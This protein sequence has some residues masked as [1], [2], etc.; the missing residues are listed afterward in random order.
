MHDFIFKAA[1]DKC[2]REIIIETD[3][4]SSLGEEL[5]QLFPKCIYQNEFL[6]ALSCDVL[7]MGNY[8]IWSI[9]DMD[10]TKQTASLGLLCEN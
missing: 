3:K 4:E 2:K 9:I 8:R 10:R 5:W 7:P 6:F 1:L